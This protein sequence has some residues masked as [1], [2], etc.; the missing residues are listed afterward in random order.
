M[1][2]KMMTEVIEVKRLPE[3]L[4]VIVERLGGTEYIRKSSVTPGD[5]DLDGEERTC[6]QYVSTGDIDRDSEILVSSGAMLSEFRKAPQV[7]WGHDYNLPP[8]GKDLWIRAT[9][10]GILAK[11]KY[12]TTDRANEVWAL[13]QGGFLRTNSVGF[14]P[15]KSLRQGEDGWDKLCDKLHTQGYTFDRESVKQIY[16]KWVL[17]EHSDVSVPANINALVVAV[18]KKE[19]SLS[20]ALIGELGLAPGGVNSKATYTCECLECGKKIDTDKHCKDIKCPACGGEMRRVERPG[21]GRGIELDN[22]TVI[23]YEDHG[24]A[25]EDMPW[26]GAAEVVAAD[27]AALKIM[28]TWFDG[29][30]PDIKGSYKLPH[31]RSSGR[32]VAVWRGVAAAMAVLFG[33]RG[34]VN[35]PSGDRRSM[36]N[37]LA[38]HYKSWDKEPPEFRAYSDGELKLLFADVW[39]EIPYMVHPALGALPNEHHC[40]LLTEDGWEHVYR[41]E[42]K[43]AAGV[44]SIWGVKDGTPKLQ[45][46]CFDREAF[47]IWDVK[48]WAKEHGYKSAEFS[49]A[50]G[51][52]ADERRKAEMVVEPVAGPPSVE[53]IADPPMPE[54]TPYI[55][56]VKEPMF[57]EVAPKSAQV[58]VVELVKHELGRQLGKV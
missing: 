25:P 12:A 6:V 40:K 57:V 27:A 7:L 30:N 17:L 13:K 9:P 31:H 8:I 18:S 54:S 55:E 19:L 39:P 1:A 11:T 16:T 5:L 21:P 34:G 4:R 26:D 58:T 45:A 15:V 51:S 23:A 41:Q 46:L 43:P 48:Y 29:E 37:H 47:S 22:K 28:C 38:K 49:P 35:V 20:D 10:K 33:A 24:A 50:T 14:M 36:Y 3:K 56:V 42:N 53:K 2:E 44:H 32:H 52:T